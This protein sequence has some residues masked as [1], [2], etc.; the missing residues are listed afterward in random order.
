LLIVF[1][2]LLN[3]G[4]T[5]AAWYDDTF[6]YRKQITIGNSG[7][8]ITSARKVKI[9]VDTA[10]L[11]SAGKMQSNCNDTRFTNE[12]GELLQ[13][14][15]DTNVDACNTSS[16]D[17]Y[18]KINQIANPVQYIYMY[19]GNP[20]APNGREGDFFTANNEGVGLVGSW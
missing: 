14:F 1:L 6:S 5:K 3:A 20:S 2:N 19:Y 13:F 7:A 9:E 17:Y 11:I 18:V 15:I 10:T 12:K 8:A 4:R 16:T